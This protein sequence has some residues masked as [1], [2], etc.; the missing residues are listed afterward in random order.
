MVKSELR[1]WGPGGN[2]DMQQVVCSVNFKGGNLA[3][4]LLR[5]SPS[6]SEL[7]CSWRKVAEFLAQVFL[8]HLTA[9]TVRIGSMF[10]FAEVGVASLEFSKGDDASWGQ[11]MTMTPVCDLGEALYVELCVGYYM[12]AAQ[13]FVTVFPRLSV[14]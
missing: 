1:W 12:S 9:S 4:F 11:M 10:V 6:E 8:C 2:D 5:S 7:R 14:N 3:E 13:R